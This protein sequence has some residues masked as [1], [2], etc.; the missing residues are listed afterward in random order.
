MNRVMQRDLK[1]ILDTALAAAEPGKTVR[2]FL[3]TEGGC[4]RVGDESFEPER[5]FVLA[6]GKASGPMARAAGEVLGEALSGGLCVIKGGHE[7]PPESF[8][9]VVAGHPEPDEGSVQAAER[10][11]ELLE[12]LEERDLLLVLVSGGAGG[13]P[14]PPAAKISPHQF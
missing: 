5:V 6:V 9:T 11:E 1:E 7:E 13:G 4:V 2:R 3:S 12:G 14:A 8:E 10:A